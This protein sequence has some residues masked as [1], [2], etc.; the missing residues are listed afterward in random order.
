M[1]VLERARAVDRERLRIARDLHDDLGGGLTEISL[2]SALAQD[3][4]LPEH[5]VNGYIREI[6]SRSAEMVNALDE[7][8]WAVNPKNDD[9]NSLVTYLCQYA[10]RFCSPR[11]CRAAF[12]S[13]RSFR[14]CP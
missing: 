14:P 9:R 6:T 10:G 13:R 3:Q 12:K 4:S 8:V 5:E 11:L 7:I 2:N 1:E